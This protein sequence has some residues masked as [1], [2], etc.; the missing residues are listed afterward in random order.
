MKWSSDLMEEFLGQMMPET[1]VPIVVRILA[2]FVL[3]SV[4]YNLTY[5]TVSQKFPGSEVS[6]PSLS[7]FHRDNRPVHHTHAISLQVDITRQAW[8]VKWTTLL[9]HAGVGLAALLCLIEEYGDALS[10]TINQRTHE[11]AAPLSNRH[12]EL[13]TTLTALSVGEVP[14]SLNL[15]HAS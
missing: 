10:Q 12:S 7:R 14:S 15:V 4:A 6:I 1:F 2:G 8:A 3:L 13:A 9:H 5:R 11:A